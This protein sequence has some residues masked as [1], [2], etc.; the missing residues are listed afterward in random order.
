MTQSAGVAY[1]M[2]GLEKVVDTSRYQI[3]CITHVPILH[4]K[5]H[6]NENENENDE[7]K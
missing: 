6:E 3:P 1:H 4:N 5:R 2:L 7:H